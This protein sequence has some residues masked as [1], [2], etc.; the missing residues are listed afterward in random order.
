MEKKRCPSCR[1]VFYLRPQNSKQHYCS[2][3]ECQKERRR[4]WQKE[5]RQTDLDYKEN[6][7]RAQK[8]W[9]Q[10]NADYWQNYRKKIR[11]SDVEYSELSGSS[12]AESVDALSV[13]MDA[14]SS[15]SPFESGIYRLQKHSASGAVKMDVWMVKITVI[16]IE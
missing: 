3:S 8:S 12:L 16:S 6:Q 9:C 10:R 4:R 2:R 11:T 14:S 1:G 5:K 15:N 13:K 7:R